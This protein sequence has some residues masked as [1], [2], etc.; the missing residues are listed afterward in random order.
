MR[1]HVNLT[2]L[3]A[4]SCWLC[5]CSP[6]EPPSNTA[7]DANAVHAA[8]IALDTHVDIDLDFATDAVDPLDA[9]L[10]VNLTNMSAGGLDA[11]FFIVYVPQTARTPENYAQAR[12]EA[13]TKFAAIHRMAEVLYPERIEIAYTASD[14]ERIAAAGKLVAA[15]GIENGY[16]IGKDLALIDEYA[17][18]GARYVTLVHNG[19]N[20]LG[21]SAQPKP[22][23]GDPPADDV[24]GLTSLGA[25]AIARL[26]R[27]GIMVDV[28]HGSKG[29]ALDATRLS[30]APVIASHSGVRGLVDHPRNMD[31]ETLLALRDNGGVVQIVAFDSYL[32]AQPPERGVAVR[33]LREGRGAPNALELAN[34]SAVERAEF[35][36]S[37]AEIDARFPRATVADLVDHIDYAVRVI[38]IDHVGISSDFGGGGGVV[39]WAN[40]GETM[41]VT[42]E[43]VAR[44]YRE[45]D[46]AKLWSGNL[47]RVWRA[48]EHVAADLR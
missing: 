16:V 40:A 32:K 18:R 24:T 9:K 4:V 5:A 29:T 42:R 48:A 10:Q 30:A 3:T 37:M 12:A 17:A 39:G 26:N 13:L 43:L 36:R 44:G 23:L 35:E 20:D 46:I 33:A 11:A 1:F 2:H 34:M 31:D 6:E 19:D 22:E 8:V 45:P 25:Q 38:G 21:R 27:A 15:I 7:A 28:S 14:V 41:N 47:L